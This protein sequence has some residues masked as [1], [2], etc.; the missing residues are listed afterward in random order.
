MLD[1]ASEWAPW[2]LPDGWLLHDDGD[3]V[4]A[5]KP[6]G[7]SVAVTEPGSKHDLTARVRLLRGSLQGELCPHTHL[8][9]DV[10]GVVVFA[11]R[12][13][14]N[15]GLAHQAARH[16]ISLTF[17]AGVTVEGP[18]AQ[19]GVLRSR[20]TKDRSGILR[21]DPRGDDT[22][23]VRY[24]VL[25]REG[26]RALV[27]ASSTGGA[28][29]IRAVFASAGVFVGGDP[30]F[31]QMAPRLMLHAAAVSLQHPRS[32]Q[33]LAVEAP[34]PWLFS[35]W[36]HGRDGVEQV[37]LSKYPAM[38]QELAAARYAL[39]VDGDL[40]AFRLVHGEAEG[41]RG[42]DV[43]WFGGYA[44]VWVNDTISSRVVDEVV[45]ALGVL[46][47]RGIYLKIRPR[48]ASRVPDA[49]DAKLV[50]PNAVRGS[51]A[52]G[53]L[54]VR[55]GGLRYLV[56]LGEGLSTGLFL[57]QRI[58]RKWL[59]ESSP[60]KRV[61]NLFAYTCSFTV[62][63]AAGGSTRTVSVDISKR[64][65]Q[66]G[67]RNLAINGLSDPRHELVCD[68]VRRWLERACRDGQRFDIIVFDPPSF[69]SSRW[70]RFTA[71]KDYVELAS[72]CMRLMSDGGWLLACTNHRKVDRKR[73]R[74]WLREAAGRV[75][76]RVVTCREAPM[77]EDFPCP[78]GGEPHMK[79]ILCGLGEE[80][81]NHQ[82]GG[83]SSGLDR[84]KEDR[85]GRR[86]RR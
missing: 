22:A 52:P 71:T 30:V 77:G 56:Q 55:E 74:V 40:D 43:E 76:R 53:P 79:A 7:V 50:C 2:A 14:A 8:D 34:W 37:A 65:L 24:R 16:Q 27:E 48:Q 58:N 10:S 68:D 18:L 54:E 26:D 81:G 86:G 60:G 31:G 57:D 3:V 75:G 11:G 42:L 20:V 72:A 25:E 63:A 38:I 44:V 66:M 6:V 84:S 41:L 19:G 85:L 23:T 15:A 62:A 9:R 4:V 29:A 61:L 21:P 1:H 33:P 47:P 67:E 46:H 12:R 80:A 5:C 51:D 36:L 13:E 78:V 35:C 45:N 28:R 49:C 59:L 64:A 69:G 17:V 70:G 83:R 82:N 32:G 73:L 39:L